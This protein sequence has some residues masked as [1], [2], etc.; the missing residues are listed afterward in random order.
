MRFFDFYAQ[1]L[2]IIDGSDKGISSH[3]S[4][5][6]E[7]T[8]QSCPSLRC[9]YQ[10]LVHPAKCKLRKTFQDKYPLRCWEQTI[11]GQSG[12][13]VHES[14]AIFKNAKVFDPDRWLQEDSTSLEKWLVAFSKGPRMCMG[15]KSVFT[16]FP[17]I[18]S[19]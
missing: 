2:K 16:P 8:A 1:E 15:Q 7:S 12:S 13:F 14:E 5:G 9:D 11:V 10:W 3:Q 6:S 17:L 4:R 19:R 18:T